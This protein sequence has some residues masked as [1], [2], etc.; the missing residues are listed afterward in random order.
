MFRITGDHT[1]LTHT[2]KK[3][4][5]LP[6][7]TALALFASCGK[8]ETEAERNAE[9]ERQV[10]QKLAAEHQADEQQRLGQTQADLD[11]RE[12]ALADKEAAA[13]MR[14]PTATPRV[15][16]SSATPRRARET[17]ERRSTASYGTF[18]R[19]LEPYGA[20]RETNDYGYVWQPR[21]AEQSR[22][23]RPYTDGHW[24]YTDAG[25]TWVSEEPF[26]WATYHYGRWVRLRSVGWCWVPGDEWAPAWVSWRTSNEY[27]G[28]APLPPEAHFDRRSGIHNWADNYY[29]IGPEQYAFVSANEL[30]AQRIERAVV[31]VERNVTIVN[32]TTN[33]T[34]I[35][36]NNT[37]IVNQ[38]PNYEEYRSRSQQ[39]IERYRLETRTDIS[40]ESARPIV[41][42]EMISMAAPVIGISSGYDRPPTVRE[43]LTQAVV[44]TGWGAITD[45]SAAEKTRAKMKAEAT[46]PP[47]APSRTFVKPETVAVTS[48]TAATPAPTSAATA[49]GSQPEAAAITPTATAKPSA[50][51]TATASPSP[52]ATPK[53]TATAT[54]SPSPSAT[55]KATATPSPAPS[56]SESAPASPSAAPET[57]AR[58]STGR[59]AQ[60]RAAEDRRRQEAQAK[61]AAQQQKQVGDAAKKQQEKEARQAQRAEQERKQNEMRNA[62]RRVP[63]APAADSAPATEAAVTPRATPTPTATPVAEPAES[64]SAASTPPSAIVTPPPSEATTDVKR[65]PGGK[66]SEN[67]HRAAAADPAAAAA[68]Q[69]EPN[70]AADASASPSA[71]AVSAPVG[72]AKKDKNKHRGPGAAEAPEAEPTEATPEPTAEP[73]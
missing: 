66:K 70:P 64:T 69:A 6:I 29:D 20:W 40:D 62:Q 39:P 36:Y 44:D 56:E 4:Y 21:Q 57:S 3:F 22:G 5:L 49:T 19:K 2:M 24:V 10:Q 23:W 9:I 31:P 59:D 12:K 13:A 41:R 53:A 8:Q 71:T 25:W 42:G 38:G 46:P 7:V 50:T 11:A 60:R 33:V 73:Q 17:S 28:W 51:A 16:Q 58:M 72:K 27:V 48:S 63:T 15:A 67:P 37:T 18:Y 14:T 32:E 52:S 30:G 45:R 55:P 35:T 54:A 1:G 65:H 43:R 61:I 47:N 26:G 68:Q 34:N